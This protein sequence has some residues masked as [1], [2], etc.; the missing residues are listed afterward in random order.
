MIS[1]MQAHNFLFL[2]FLLSS[3]QSFACD[4]KEIQPL[5][6]TRAKS[7]AWSYVVF[8]GELTGVD[9]VSETYTFTVLELFKGGT[10]HKTLTGKY[11]NSCSKMPD[12]KGR[13]LVYADVE[14]DFINISDCLASRS[15]A[16]PFCVNCLPPP[17]PPGLEK[18]IKQERALAD[19]EKRSQQ[20]W[21][22]ELEWLRSK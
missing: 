17:P 14:G 6:T 15:E 2:F 5:D 1:S 21:H 11:F 4:C 12:E 10:T 3:T 19:H 7:F 8:L 13:W 16:K 9:T 20:K 18:D 22:E